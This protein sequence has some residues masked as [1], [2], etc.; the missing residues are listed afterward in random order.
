MGT[1][2]MNAGVQGRVKLMAQ[3]QQEIETAMRAM[4][5]AHRE[6]RIVRD[7][8]EKALV[9]LDPST[10]E[11]KAQQLFILSVERAMKHLNQSIMDIPDEFWTMYL[12]PNHAGVQEVI[13][14]LKVA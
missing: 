9:T 8:V 3:N 5:N 13:R 14:A 10:E 12:A 4:L 1:I 11:G 6:L 7:N 2:S